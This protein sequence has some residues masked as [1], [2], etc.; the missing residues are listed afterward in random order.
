M[1]A[2]GQSS[3][4]EALG[5]IGVLVVSE[6][7]ALIHAASETLRSSG[8]QVIGCL[9]PAHARCKLEDHQSCPLADHATIAL[10]DSPTTGAFTRHW[11]IVQSGTYAER[12]QRMHPDCTVILC[13]APEGA[14]GPS[15]EVAHATSARSA[16]ALLH[17]LVSNQPGESASLRPTQAR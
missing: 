11:K 3:A 15:G 17:A 8:V 5:E 2:R 4:T 1:R 10:I 13:G 14:A 7:P 6:E 12:L 16:L 9:G